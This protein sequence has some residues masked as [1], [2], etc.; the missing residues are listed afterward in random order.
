MKIKFL[1]ANNGDSI[2]INFKD[3]EGSIRNI[4]IDGG[5]KATYRN[6]KRSYGALKNELDKIKSK[7]EKI[8]LL[9]LSHIDNDHIEG[10]LTWFELDKEAPEII[11][12]VW[13][14]SGK[15][16]AK[17]FKQP[18]NN[19]LNVSLSDSSNV[20]T[21]VDEGITFEKYLETNKLWDGKIIKK[22][23]KWEAYGLNF[24]V[25]TPTDKQLKDLVELYEEETGDSIYTGGANDWAK[26]LEDIILEEKAS[27]YRFKQDRSEKN[28][29]SITSIMNYKGKNFLFLA[30]SHPKAVC[31]SLN[32]IGYSK[33]NPLKVD[34]MQVSHHGSKSNNSKELF[35]LIETDSYAISTSSSG[36]NHPHK[37]TIARIVQKNPEATI[38]S[39]YEKVCNNILTD[40]DKADYPKLRI[41]LIS[42]YIVD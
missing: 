32:D 15:S 14:N 18:I 25:L 20:L 12:E 1:K 21:G 10:F 39:N 4:L 13:F 27:N 34:L 41:K 16:I 30:D 37:Y 6:K 2:L 3:D 40:K 28:G 22:D 26:N 42:E 31:K 7:K 23:L 9:I 24:V 35:N 11:T 8:D 17:N 5:T 29:S 36:H 38:Y 19:G 33:E